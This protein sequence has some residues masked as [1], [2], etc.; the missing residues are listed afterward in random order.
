MHIQNFLAAR[1]SCAKLADLLFYKNA[2]TDGSIKEIDFFSELTLKKIFFCY[3][4]KA[5]L[6]DIN[7]QIARGEKI[8][9]FGPSG[10]GKSTIGKLICKILEPQ[11]GEILINGTDIRAY[12]LGAVTSVFAYVSA[13]NLVFDAS[14]RDN[15]T[16]YNEK[17]SDEEILTVLE[18]EELTACFSFMKGKRG[19]TLLDMPL[20]R[21]MLSGGEAQLLNLCRL[22]FADKQMIVFD[23]AS[24]MIDEEIEDLFNQIFRKLTKNMTTIIITH[25]VERLKDCDYIYMMD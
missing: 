3:N 10:A 1:G 18:E 12:S 25:N 17:I 7:M 2:V 9:V 8:G 20:G 4:D 5:V 6:S 16:I 13:G 15:L 24:A 22:F 19:K 11:E 14:L 21:Q 23:E